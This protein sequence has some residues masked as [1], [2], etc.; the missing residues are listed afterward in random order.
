MT[1]AVS[2]AGPA[3]MRHRWAEPLLVAAV[4]AVALLLAHGSA[5]DAGWRWDDGGLLGL[6]LDFSPWQYFADPAV[7]R[8][9]S[10]ANVAPWNLLF[11]D[12][13]LALF[14][15]NV[16][17][18]YAHLLLLVGLGAGLLYAVLRQWL[19]LPAALAGALALV[20][21]KPLVY[22]AGGLM[23]GHYATGLVLA[24]LSV[25]AWVHHLRGAS[26][27]WWAVSALAYLL[28]TT[29]KEIYVP[30]VL[31][32]PLLPVA[33]L[34]RRALALV[35]HVLVA[36]CYVLWRQAVL[37]RL[38]GGYG[39]AAPEPAL[40]WQQLSGVPLLLAPQG[41]AG[42][43]GM[44]ALAALVIRAALQR[45]FRAL[46]S[47]AIAAVVGLPLLALVGFP[48][49]HQ[50]DRY[51]FAPWVAVCICLAVAWP[52]RLRAG[53][54]AAALALLVLTL[55]LG[56]AQER[57]RLHDDWAWWDTLS[58]FALA[59]DVQRQALYI[60]PDQGF[61]RLMF[62]QLRYVADRLQGTADEAGLEIV[63]QSGYRLRQVR[64]AGLSLF[65]YADGRM[66]QMGQE[67][68]QQLFADMDAPS[69]EVA[70]QVTLTLR[71]GVLHWEFGPHDGPYVF[72]L[73]NH[74]AIQGRN[75]GV[76]LPR[77]GAFA[78]PQGR[79]AEFAFCHDAAAPGSMACS[80]ALTL[81]L[82]EG[83]AVSWQGRGRSSPPAGAQP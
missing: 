4:L 62:G 18:H 21:G 9:H 12:I 6:A 45:R 53:A 82:P 15:M 13:N 28:A 2:G 68:L 38:I 7:M 64:A 52:R 32:L 36:A 27:G 30:L 73:R 35:P 50:A 71:A 37:G 74:P 8:L 54:A 66:V 46:P 1:P 14:G 31:V 79:R 81:E 19:A 43:A 58:A 20:L 29:C 80:P 26:R 34:R 41:W 39:G 63:D 47:L 22:V 61:R 78:W 11:Y 83:Q 57:R 33:G 16:A 55:A 48:G 5:L 3:W 17:G 24:L 42:W 65:E 56:L 72:N 25:W 70:L 59:A 60:G 23:H 69:A 76:L 49:I 10:P 67:R 77:H 75:N 51:L 44:A 40:V